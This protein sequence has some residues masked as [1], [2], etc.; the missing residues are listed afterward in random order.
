MSDKILKVKWLVADKRLIKFVDVEDSYNIADDVNIEGID[1]GSLVTMEL[2][3]NIVV[4]MALATLV[5]LLSEYLKQKLFKQPDSRV[6]ASLT[7]VEDS[8]KAKQFDYEGPIEHFE[9][10]TSKIQQAEKK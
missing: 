8:G 10:V 1:A 6:R 5:N 3:D 4:K 9:E 2:K 7:V